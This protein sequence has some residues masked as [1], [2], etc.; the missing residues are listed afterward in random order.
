[1]NATELQSNDHKGLYRE[2]RESNPYRRAR[3]QLGATQEDVALSLGMSVQNIHRLE[4]GLVNTPTFSVAE[5]LSDSPNDLVA[6]YYEWVHSMRV[7]A[8]RAYRAIHW[9]PGAAGR[10]NMRKFRTALNTQMAEQFGL[11][12]VVSGDQM[13]NKALCLHPRVLQLYYHE[14]R[15]ADGSILQLALREIGMSEGAQAVRFNEF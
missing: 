5:F 9:A 3:L 13:F 6:D 2:L 12:G 8:A 7:Y 10:D 14:G 4:N 11:M 15:I 1:M